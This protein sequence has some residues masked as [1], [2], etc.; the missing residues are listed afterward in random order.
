MICHKCN[1]SI[2]ADSKFCTQCGSK[3]ISAT[4]PSNRS[5]F[6]MAG[7][8]SCE[9]HVTEKMQHL[10]KEE[11]VPQTIKRERKNNKKKCKIIVVCLVLLAVLIMIIVV[12]C[13][14]YI[15]GPHIDKNFVETFPFRSGSI[16]EAENWLTRNKDYKIKEVDQRNGQIKILYK[17]NDAWEIVACNGVY[18]VDGF[19]VDFRFSLGILEII[20]SKQIYEKV[21][22]TI[23]DD[24][25]DICGNPEDIRA[26]GEVYEFYY[27]GLTIVVWGDSDGILVWMNY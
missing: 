19:Y 13:K 8:L 22:E 11:S 4:E 3:L 9:S 27:N 1:V 15:A 16:S 14:S 6:K 7:D 24:L 5:S 26:N 2:P 23:V 17:P 21:F 18:G 25:R 10:H 12:R 20:R